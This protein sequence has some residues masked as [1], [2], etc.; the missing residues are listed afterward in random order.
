MRDEHSFQARQRT[1]DLPHRVDR[2]LVAHP[3]LVGLQAIEKV[4]N[5]HTFLVCPESGLVVAAL[6]R[7]IDDS[8]CLT[9]RRMRREARRR[10]LGDDLMLWC[11][12]VWPSA[13]LRSATS[14][15]APVDELGPATAKWDYLDAAGNL[16]VCVYRYGP[17]PWQHDRL[18][19]L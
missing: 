11:D 9:N 17:P 10:L 16:I 4:L 8:L 19:N 12:L 13:I 5:R 3:A 14:W 7:A 6:A 1:Q 2:S 15:E 18:V